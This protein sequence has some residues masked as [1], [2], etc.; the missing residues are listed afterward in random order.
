MSI[1][2][3]L[4]IVDN[5]GRIIGKAARAV[6]HSG[7]MLLHP[8][9]HIHI[10]ANTRL[11]LQKRSYNKKIEPGKWDT[12]VGGHVVLGNTVKESAYKEAEEELGITEEIEL[13]PLMEYVWESPVENEY[14]HV[15]KAFY[16]GTIRI[17]NDE[18]IDGRFFA[19]NEIEDLVGKNFFTPN[20]EKEFEM[21]KDVLFG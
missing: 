7:S 10:V 14:V 8:V 11:F 19:K 18:V 12:S 5:N 4:P 13:I 6:C 20:F 21:I 1:S 17:D 15:F 16:S 3:E 2:E 9:V